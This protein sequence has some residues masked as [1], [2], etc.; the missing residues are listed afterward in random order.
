MMKDDIPLLRKSE[1]R[2]I[3]GKSPSRLTGIGLIFV[4]SILFCIVTVIMKGM[5]VDNIPFLQITCIRYFVVML[6]TGV[7]ITH[8]RCYGEY[9]L[10]FGRKE[11]RFILFMRGFLF[12]TAM[13]FYYWA[14]LYIPLGLATTLCYTFPLITAIFSHFGLC[15][16][17]EKLSKFG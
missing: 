13:N 5:M 7:F 1:D 17:A 2:S 6:L 8:K 9:M 11:D 16:T 12:F 14:L 15:I 4:G 10:F 3:I